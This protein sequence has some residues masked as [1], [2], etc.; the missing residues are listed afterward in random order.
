MVKKIIYLVLIMLGGFILAGQVLA[1]GG[2]SISPVTFELT[3]NPGDVLTNKLRIYNPTNSSIII[4]ME[5]EDFTARGE[6]GE[7]VVASAEN[8]TY[9]L[10]EW[11]SVEPKN[12]TVGPKEQKFIDFIITVPENAEPG[13]K[14]GSVLATIKGSIGEEITGATVAQKV[15]TLVLLTVA[16]EVKEQ[17]SVKEFSAP[18]FLEKGPVNFN[19]RFEN[20][21]TVHVRPRGFVSITDWRDKKVIDIEFP[22]KNV[23]PGAI[24][25]VDAVFEKEWLFGKYTATLVGSYGNTNN[26]FTPVVLVFWVVPWK[27]ISEILGGLLIFILVFIKIRKRL[28]LATK[29]LFKGDKARG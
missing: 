11:V 26:P 8:E 22:Q 9:S 24:R 16:G 20:T 13:G 4:E 17:V 3:A 7:V 25:K 14:Y 2:L 5:A 6:L 29:V 10:A 18:N 21:G 15:G 28:G 23:I 12:F 1:Q 27:L 19:I